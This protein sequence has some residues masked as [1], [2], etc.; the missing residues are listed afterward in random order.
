MHWITFL[1]QHIQIKYLKVPY[2]DGVLRPAGEKLPETLDRCTM[3]ENDKCP[4]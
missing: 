2:Y 3:F 4:L 1:Q